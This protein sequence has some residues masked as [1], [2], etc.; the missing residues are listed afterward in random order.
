LAQGTLLAMGASLTKQST[1]KWGVYVGN[2]AKKL[3]GKI[4]FEVY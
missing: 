4:S 2:P 1:E 3:E